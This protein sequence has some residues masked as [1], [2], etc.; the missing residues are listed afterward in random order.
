MAGCLGGGNDDTE[1]SK[2][3][4]LD[5]RPADGD[6]S[7]YGGLTPYY[8]PTHETLTASSH[9]F[10]D[11]EP[12][13]ATEWEAVDDLIWEFTL[14]TDATFH[15]GTA[16]TADLV[17]Q[18]FSA[19]LAERPL[20]WAKVT[21]DS[22]EAVDDHTL[23]VETVER[24]GALAGTMSHPLFGIQHPGDRDDPIGTGPYEV[25]ELDPDGAVRMVAADDYWGDEPSLEALTFEGIVDPMTRSS[26]LQAG[27]V[28]AAFELPREH[29]EMLSRDDSIEIRTQ[30]EP[31]TG[32]GMMNLYQSPTDD[33]DLRRAL[34]YAVDQQLIV[35]NIL[36][37]IGTPAKGPYAPSIP[38][39]AHN[40]LPEYGPDL[41]RARTLVDESGYDGDEL[42][43][44]L[45]SD[46]PHERLI[47][48][49]MQE[50]FE[51]IGVSTSIRQ[52][53]S[54]SFYEVEQKRDSNITL[55]E[56]GSIN[57]AADYLVYLQFH[58]EGGDNR[59]L[60]E[61]EGTG[62]YNLG[63]EVDSL[64]E[65][66]DRALDADR[67]HEAYREVQRRVM[68]AA[69]LIPVYYKEYVFGQR[70]ETA[71]PETHAVPHMTRWTE[72]RPDE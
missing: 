72:F 55:I 14:R 60:Y 23:R 38:W 32:L 26:N 31:R 58:S 21:E 30:E 62:L 11:I 53:E 41:D 68:D 67:K 7:M 65:N 18:S 22:F 37:G 20:G 49:H 4:A 51:E 27:D 61:T 47:A 63:G 19:L 5:S 45:G 28:D 44:H 69:V 71:G 66:G 6:W 8:T 15:D 48:S 54:G 34:N 50:R 3:V 39:S 9:D 1:L 13:L 36:H 64:I 57:G 43:I 46:N 52:F 29:Y 2:T 59:E 40:E 16:L 42:E 35:E 56:L 10:Y 12:W 17:A 24:F 33:A 25:A 70:A